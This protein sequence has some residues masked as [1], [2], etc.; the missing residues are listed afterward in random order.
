M[1]NSTT[2]RLKYF[3]F[4]HCFHQWKP[5]LFRQKYAQTDSAAGGTPVETHDV[6]KS[7]HLPCRETR[8]LCSCLRESS[9]SQ[10]CQASSRCAWGPQSEVMGH[11]G[12]HAEAG[13]SPSSP[14][15]SSGPASSA[16]MRLPL[17]REGEPQSVGT[18]VLSFCSLR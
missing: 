5:K 13:P 18:A 17:A 10:G 6:A 15:T 8:L 4:V 16:W 3:T 2:R 7:T 1:T 9:E 11:A 12:P 14:L